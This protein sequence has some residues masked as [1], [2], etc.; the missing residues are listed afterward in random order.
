M[1]HFSLFVKNSLKPAVIDRVEMNAD[2]TIARVWLNE[3]Q[4]PFAIGKSGQNILLASQITG[5][6]I[7]LVREDG[8]KKEENSDEVLNDD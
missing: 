8:E 3:D 2:N 6:T 7:Q 4:R 5:V 1:V